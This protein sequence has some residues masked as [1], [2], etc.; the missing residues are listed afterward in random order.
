M[1][2]SMPVITFV[3]CTKPELARPFY[4]GVLGLRFVVEDQFAVVFSA[5]NVMVRVVNVASVPGHV[6]AQFT[7]LGWVVPDIEDMVRS[8][9]GKGAQ[10]MRYPGMEQDLL[11]IWTSPNGAKVAWFKDPFENVLSVTEL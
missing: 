10:F 6:P 9:A 1:L 8:L 3:P 2:R 4:E 5:D 11:G 7:I